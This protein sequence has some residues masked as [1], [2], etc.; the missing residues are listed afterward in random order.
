MSDLPIFPADLAAMS[1]GQLVAMPITDFVTAERHVDEA[2]AYLKHLRAKLDAAKLRRFGEAAHAALRDS[3]RD[4]GTV[5]L[6]Y[7]A[8]CVKYELP[9]K[10]TW[11]QALLKAMAQRIAATGDEIEDYIDIKLSVPESRYG[12][13]P[14]TLQ[15]Q[16]AA[17]RTVDSGKPSLTLSFDSE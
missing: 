15:Q 4:F 2:L 10:V 3:G 14:L 16:F 12:N 7:G 13:W 9:K 1:M 17:A 5:H 6:R 11:D 8:L